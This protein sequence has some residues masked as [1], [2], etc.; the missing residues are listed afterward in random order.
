VTRHGS[1]LLDGKPQILWQ[2]DLAQT[3]AGQRQ[4]PG[5]ATSSS[6]SSCSSAMARF[7]LVFDGGSAS[8]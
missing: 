7:R 5:S 3:V 2:F 8:S 6:P 4:S 1:R